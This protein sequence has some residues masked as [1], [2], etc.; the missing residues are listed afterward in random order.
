MVFGLVKMNYKQVIILRKDLKMSKGK[1]IA[2]ALHACLAS[3]KLGNKKIIKKWEKEGAKKVVL[4]A[5]LSQMKRIAKKLEK[6]KI[7]FV[8]IRDAGL[9]QLRKGSITAIGIEPIEEEKIDQ[10]TGNLKLY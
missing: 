4:K 9:T 3:F 1:A 2:Q 6:E 8:V 10:I 5:T 7:K